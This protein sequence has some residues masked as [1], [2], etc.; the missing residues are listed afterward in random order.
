MVVAR[1]ADVGVSDRGCVRGAFWRGPSIEFVVEDGFEGAI[2]PGADLDGPLGG[3][4]DA[5]RAK[6]ADEPDDAE[7]GAIALLGMGPGLEDL[8]ASPV[9]A[10]PILRASS[11]MRSIVQ[12]A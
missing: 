6:G 10:G 3:G 12:P 11:R 8:L 1:P 2:G 7:T 4:L 5:R 9:V